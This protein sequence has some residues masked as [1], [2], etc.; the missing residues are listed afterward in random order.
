MTTKSDR[1]NHGIGLR[2][3]HSIVKKYNGIIN[4]SMQSGYFTV[5]VMLELSDQETAFS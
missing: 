2:V 3:I 5:D 1:H 4:T